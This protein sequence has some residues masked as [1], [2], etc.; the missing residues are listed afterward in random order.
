MSRPRLAI[1]LLLSLTA[2]L[3]WLAYSPTVLLQLFQFAGAA[4]E[5]TRGPT[6][7]APTLTA[8][9]GELPT[10][11]V[12]F[13]EWANGQRVGSGFLLEAP[14]NLVLGVT[15]A[16]SLLLIGPRPIVSFRLPQATNA[17]ITFTGFYGQTG[18]AFTSYNFDMDF[19]FF[20]LAEIPAE[21]GVLKPDVRGL[22]ELGERVVLYS[23]L[24]DGRGQPRALWGTVTAAA[25]NA[26]WVQMDDVFEANGLSG[27]PLL[28]A[29]TGQVVGM[30]VSA[31]N[32]APILLGFHPIGS[33]VEK[34]KAIERIP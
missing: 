27:S 17:F 12:S 6:P 7:P 8:P 10:G 32:P 19:V 2:F 31:T 25:P 29:H 33:L 5:P 24:G 18:T 21:A 13:E 22:P 9:R 3:V 26:V 11:H 20:S 1:F 28:S 16:H 14:N 23:G 4:I 34:A 15:T 30:A